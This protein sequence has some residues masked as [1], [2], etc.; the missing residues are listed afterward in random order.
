[1]NNPV[2]IVGSGIAGLN[3]ALKVSEKF[4]VVLLTKSELEESSTYYAQGGV[5]SVLDAHDSFENHIEDTLKAGAYYNNKEM[6]E[7]MVKNGPAA[8]MGLLGM[9]ADFDEQ[10]GHL[11]LAREGGHSANRI[12]HKADH[13]GREIESCLI[14]KVKQNSNIKVLDNA[15]AVNLIVRDNQVG[16]LEYIFDNKLNFVASS[17]V[18]LCTGGI[19][20]LYKF[21]SN[22][23][24][25][26]GDGIAMAHR[27]GAKVKDMEFLQ[28][29][30]T[31]F[32]AKDGSMKLISEAVRG[33]GAHLVNENGERFVNELSPRDEVA[34]AIYKQ[35]ESYLDLRHLEAN[36]VKKR[37]PSIYEMVVENGLDLTS[38]LI[39]V[40]PAAHYACGGIE[41]DKFG[42]TSVNGL[43]A[44]GECAYTGVHGANR[45]ASNSLL[46]ALVF[47]SSLAENLD[48]NQSKFEHEVKGEWSL[49]WPDGISQ[50]QEHMWNNVGVVR[51]ENHLKESLE[52]IKCQEPG[53]SIIYKNM[54]TVGELIVEAALSRSESLGC[55]TVEDSI[56]S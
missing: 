34:L 16:G 1:M 42:R 47:S 31:C 30:P 41:I 32:K 20:Q 26:T 6:V 25:S 19:G 46:E 24:V 55:H 11:A 7:F 15:F 5:A 44:F 39:P 56:S 8:I 53:E 37:F 33:E 9:G 45:L 54:L 51:N 22:P 29:H 40:Q 43:Y 28:F 23:L 35:S 17:A 21:T 36:Y 49:D 50:L 13:T 3:F 12:V 38:N 27:A 2:V 14:S 52:W 4:E 48:P 18:V 10:N